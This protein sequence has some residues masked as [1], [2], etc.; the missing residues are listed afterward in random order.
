MK[1]YFL[2]DRDQG[3]ALGKDNF[4][5]GFEFVGPQE[6]SLFDLDIKEGDGLFVKVWKG[7]LLIGRMDKNAVED[8]ERRSSNTKAGSKACGGCGCKSKETC[9]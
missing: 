5:E 8:I 2:N 1:V 6:G 4:L 7:Q 3:L 9:D